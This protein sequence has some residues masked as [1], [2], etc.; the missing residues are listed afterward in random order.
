MIREHE[1]NL[2]RV[3]YRKMNKEKN[4]QDWISLNEFRY[5]DE[6]KQILEMK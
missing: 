3:Y 1:H 4:Y 5:C 2:K 6:C